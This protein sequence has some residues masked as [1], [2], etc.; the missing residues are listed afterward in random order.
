[1]RN[2]DAGLGI[3]DII[4]RVQ[5]FK[6]GILHRALRTANPARQSMIAIIERCYRQQAISNSNKTSISISTHNL[7]ITRS[8]A[9]IWWIAH[10]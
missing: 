2:Q 3:P 9:L 10:I 1:M 8:V 4:T 5:D 6:S 7:I